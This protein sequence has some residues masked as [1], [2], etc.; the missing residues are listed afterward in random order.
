MEGVDFS[1]I[2]K[3]VIA[4]SSFPTKQS[5][6]HFKQEGIKIVINCTEFD[7]SSNVPPEFQSYHFPI[8]DFGLVSHKNLQRFLDTTD[9]F[10]KQ[11]LPIVVHCLA[12][13]GRTGQMIIAFCANHNLIPNSI[14][15]VAWLRCL[16]PCCLETPE[17]EHFGIHIYAELQK[18][19][20]FS[21]MEE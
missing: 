18:I 6:T 13:C 5:F 9:I 4:A 15:P 10:Y 14:E 12:G 17:Q 11:R 1:W 7:N 20:N 8:Q 3:G 21:K 16:R 19:A 2:V